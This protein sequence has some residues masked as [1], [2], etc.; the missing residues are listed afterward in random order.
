MKTEIVLTP[1]QQTAFNGL[2]EGITVG[3]VLV[4]RGEPGRGMTTILEMLHAARGGVIIGVREFLAG[5]MASDPLAIEEAF[6]R[7]IE[8]AMHAHDLVIVDDL[9][10]VTN[11]VDNYNY[12]RRLSAGCGSYCASRRG[13]CPE[14]DTRLRYPRRRA[15][16]D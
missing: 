9:H 7:M 3:R 8:D 13:P 15:L 6:L 2:L 11:I 5:L 14:Q 1:V 4:L 16:V 10:L 12:S